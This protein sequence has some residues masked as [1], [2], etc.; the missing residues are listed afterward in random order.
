MIDMS[1]SEIITRSNVHSHTTFADG[2]DTAEEMVRAAL[3][4]GFHTL[5]FSEHGHADYDDCSMSLGQEP[6]YRAEISRLKACR[7]AGYIAGLRTR[8]AL[9]DGRI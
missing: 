8:L 1:T 5:G 3:A 9:R 4:L 2:R 6:A 7:R